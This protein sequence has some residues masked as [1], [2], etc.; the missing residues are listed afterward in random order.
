MKVIQGV[1]AQLPFV[2]DLITAEPEVRYTFH[3]EDGEIQELTKNAPP[4]PA[5][6]ISPAAGVVETRFVLDASQSADA[7]SAELL[8]RWDWENDG[9]WDTEW[10]GPISG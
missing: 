7:E 5:V 9:V 2:V 4:I 3:H 6:T 10:A 1:N 8:F